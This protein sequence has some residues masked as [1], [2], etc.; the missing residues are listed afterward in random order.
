MLKKLQKRQT[1][2]VNA[3]VEQKVSIQHSQK[4][5]LTACHRA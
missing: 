2:L 1:L 4:L 5:V 3:E